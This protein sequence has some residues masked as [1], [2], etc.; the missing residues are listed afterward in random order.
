MSEGAGEGSACISYCPHTHLGGEGA[1]LEPP[2]RGGPGG[3]SGSH[4]VLDRGGESGS[5]GREAGWGGGGQGAAGE[6]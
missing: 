3:V 6:R 2:E 4:F 5:G 1:E